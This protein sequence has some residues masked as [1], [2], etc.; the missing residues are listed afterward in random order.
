MCTTTA[1]FA[2]DDG[3]GLL[4]RGTELVEVV[5]E[6]DDKAGYRVEP[7]EEAAVETRLDTRRL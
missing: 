2:T 5:A 1:G 6:E 3:A 7:G 4:Y